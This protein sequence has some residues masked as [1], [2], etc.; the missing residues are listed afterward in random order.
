[1]NLKHIL[2][3]S[4]NNRVNLILIFLLFAGLAQCDEELSWPPIIDSE[5]TVTKTRDSREILRYKH[6]ERKEWGYQNYPNLKSLKFLADVPKAEQEMG[7]AN[8]T[9]NSS[10]FFIVEPKILPTEDKKAPLLVILHGAGGSGH[11]FLKNHFIDK[12]RKNKRFG[13]SMKPITRV[14]TPPEDCYGL[15]I[16]CGIGEWWGWARYSGKK[17]E[18]GKSD[19]PTTLRILDYIKWV[20]KN[21]LVDENRVYLTGSSMGGCGT[22]GIGGPHGDIFAAI[23]AF[24]PAGTEYFIRSLGLPNAPESVKANKKKTK[25]EALADDAGKGKKVKAFPADFDSELNQRLIKWK[26]KV[27]MHKLK[28]PPYILTFS[29]TTDSW[30]KTQPAFLHA[31]EAAKIP[32]VAGWGKTGHKSEPTILAA[33]RPPFAAAL[34]F[35]WMEIRKNEAYPVFS[36]AEINDKPPWITPDVKNR[37]APGQLNAYFRWENKLDTLNKFS[38]HLWL[39]QA[40]TD[41]MDEDFK[42]STKTS[43][44]LRRL[45]KFIV[46]ANKKFQ[47]QLHRDE[48]L[49]SE[50]K[51]IADQHGLLTIAD[52]EISMTKSSLVLSPI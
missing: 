42:K 43:I 1:M 50:G 39:E 12:V 45:Q 26:E 17:S 29:G 3:L 5:S 22:L 2:K 20:K 32:V 40:K 30:S 25:A 6:G 24:V 7:A 33:N 10:A 34:A 18:K 27:L 8:K 48:K 15:Y 44:T 38:I 28:D 37:N 19:N 16:N 52:L 14:F 11:L 13:K 49:I 47:Y 31:V 4:L 51:V 21:F 9:Q 46:E 36:E 23:A 35:P 41:F